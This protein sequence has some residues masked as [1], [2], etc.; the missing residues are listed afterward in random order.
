MERAKAKL[1]GLREELLPTMVAYAIMVKGSQWKD[2]VI[3]R[4]VKC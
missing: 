4:N 3:Q 2:P 1:I